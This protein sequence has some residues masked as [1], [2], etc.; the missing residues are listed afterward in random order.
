MLRALGVR[1][2]CGVEVGKD[3]TIPELREQGFKAF[4]LG[5]GLQNGGKLGIREA[6]TQQAS[7]QALT[8]SRTSTAV[9]M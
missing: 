3:V 1:F 8:S 2:R 5:I 9:M 4:Y 6:T 7:W